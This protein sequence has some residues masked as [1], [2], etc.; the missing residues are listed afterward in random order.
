M[1]K[2]VFVGTE[3]SF[4]REHRLERLLLFRIV[5]FG[6]R[7]ASCFYLHSKRFV[8]CF[9][10]AAANTTIFSFIFELHVDKLVLQVASCLYRVITF[11]GRCFF[12][13]LVRAPAWLANADAL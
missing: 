5:W 10:A 7:R 9:I 12:V 3:F 6:F 8:A 13:L 1:W 11:S 2:K 4:V